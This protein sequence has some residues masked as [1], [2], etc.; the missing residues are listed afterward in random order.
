MHI[1]LVFP[2]LAIS[3]CCSAAPIPQEEPEFSIIDLDDAD[4]EGEVRRRNLGGP[5][6]PEEA[7]AIL[8]TA[9]DQISRYNSSRARRFTNEAKFILTLLTAQEEPLVEAQIEVDYDPDFIE[10]EEGVA[11]GHTPSASTVRKILN[12]IDGTEGQKRR[13]VES[14]EKLYP[15]FHRNYVARFEQNWP[16]LTSIKLKR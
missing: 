10:D 9:I 7:M 6:E 16:A 5:W 14:V 2:I 4:L 13:S 12:M 15:W 1:S 8:N 3:I 11:T